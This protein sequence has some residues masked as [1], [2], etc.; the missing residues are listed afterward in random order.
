MNDKEENN[1]EGGGEM[2]KPCPNCGKLVDVKTF[3]GKG[4]KEEYYYEERPTTPMEKKI[5][6][7]LGIPFRHMV[8]HVCE[9]TKKK[10]NK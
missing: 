1:E 6:K 7:R 10:G 9:S 8:E 5:E 2:L 4:K 3:D